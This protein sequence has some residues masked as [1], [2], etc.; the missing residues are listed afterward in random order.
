MDLGRFGSDYT[1]IFS[2]S[3]KARR[4]KSVGV[5]SKSKVAGWSRSPGVRGVAHE[6]GEFGDEGTE[7]VRRDTVF[8]DVRVD[9][10]ER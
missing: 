7:T 10:L 3:P 6:G 2:I 1:V 9:F 5:V 4:C 8:G